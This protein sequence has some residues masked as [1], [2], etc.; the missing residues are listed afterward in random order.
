MG[1]E[2]T[3]WRLARY[4]S[5]LFG[6]KIMLDLIYITWVANSYTIFATHLEITMCSM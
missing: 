5:M 3:I 1:E 6:I 2:F 4:A